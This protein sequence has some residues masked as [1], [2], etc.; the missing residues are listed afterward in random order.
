M[1]NDVA[2]MRES[3]SETSPCIGCPTKWP[4]SLL[5][6]RNEGGEPPCRLLH[7]TVARPVLSVAALLATTIC[8]QPPADRRRL[9]ATE[10][11]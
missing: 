6:P 8:P 4:I 9:D 5:D 10:K 3:C 11:I 2:A 1:T 7:H